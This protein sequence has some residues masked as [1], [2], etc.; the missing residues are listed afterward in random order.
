MNACSNT[1]VS[2]SRNDE[3]RSYVVKGVLL[4]RTKKICSGN[5]IDTQRSKGGY[6]LGDVGIRF[7]SKESWRY[8]GR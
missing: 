4:T 5:P 7:G 2:V 1:R 6:L 8:D 3:V